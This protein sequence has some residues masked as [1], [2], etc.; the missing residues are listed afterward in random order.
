MQNLTKRR[1]I[2]LATNCILLA[3]VF[4]VF[5]VGFLPAKIAPIFRM[6]ASVY[7]NGNLASSK[8]S[9]MFNVYEGEGEI[10]DIL[11]ILREKSVKATFFMGGCFAALHEETVRK[12]VLEGHELANHGYFHKQHDKLSLQDNIMEIRACESVLESICGIKPHLFAPPSGAY[13]RTTVEAAKELGY[14]TIMWTK[15]TID[16]R[17]SSP[18]VVFSRATKNPKGGDLILMHPKAV[19]VSVLP[20]IIDF[21]IGKGLR[22]VTV[23][24]NIIG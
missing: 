17:D 12:I 1:R 7:Y 13:S 19:T 5:A 18:S 6:D 11:S 22:P 21:Y 2:T 20:Q 23:S 16:W 10:E 9:L 14:L 8:V 24:E 15:D 3:L 4:F